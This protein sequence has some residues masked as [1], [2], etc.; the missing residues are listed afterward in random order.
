MTGDHTFVSD[1][2]SKIKKYLNNSLK[3]ELSEEKTVITNL[4]SNRAMFLGTEISTPKPDQSKII[5]KRDRM[6][7]K[8]K[9][10]VNHVRVFFHA[11]IEKIID[12][13]HKAG[14]TKDSKGTPGALKK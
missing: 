13:L 14:F 6:G 5:S 11:P 1:L 9:A 7:K 12:R 8:I 3:L 4:H 2:K 10:R